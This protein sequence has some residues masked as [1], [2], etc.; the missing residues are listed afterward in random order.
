MKTV[1]IGSGAGGGIA[2]M[3]RA[4]AG[5]EVVM[6]EKGPW[7]R[8]RDY[9]DDEIKFGS[10]AMI[11]QDPRIHPRVAR[12]AGA[13]AYRGRILPASQCVGGGTVHYAA[14]SFRLRPEDFAVLDAFGPVAGANVQNWP[15][16]YDDLE[17]YYTRVE[18]LIG[19]Q[20]LDTGKSVTY[21]KR[22]GGVTRELTLEGNTA[23]AP[24]SLPYPMPP[25][26]GKIDN[27]LFAAAAK[28]LGFHPYPCPLAVNS[29][30]YA[31][32]IRGPRDA[33]TGEF[34][35]LERL[36]QRPTCE[37][38]GMC[39]GYG[40]PIDAKNSTLVTAI[41]A[42]EKRPNFRLIEQAMATEIVWEQVGA[43]L[44]VTG[45]RYRRYGEE[46]KIEPLE[47][48][49]RL[50]VAADAIE[51]PRLFLLSKLDAFD[52]SGDLGCNLMTNHLP[53]AIGFFPELVNNHRGVYTTH[54]IDDLWMIPWDALP[55]KAT[56]GLPSALRDAVRRIGLKGGTVAAAGP[57]AGE[58]FGI[59]GL[60][61]LGQ[62]L[63][64]GEAH[65][66]AMQSAFGHSIYL[67][68]VGDDLPQKTNRVTLAEDVRDVHG[69]PVARIEQLPHPRELAVLA[70]AAP[71]LQSILAKAGAAISMALSA[72][73]PVYPS[74]Y[75]HR[76]GTMRMGTS[77]KTSVVDPDGRFW[78]A[79]NLYVMDGSVMASAGG[80][81]PTE[82]IQAI[83]WMLAERL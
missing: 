46:E 36:R 69:V 24:R 42:I 41:E 4:R 35:V 47:K 3:V 79:D 54:V 62:T 16:T 26:P 61:A 7:W 51:T 38:C 25:G 40:C 19:V 57:S 48:G 52:E 8:G 72:T 31:S 5:D 71:I 60:V 11:N 12:I 29:V 13:D 80:H 76:M 81:N 43:A 1:I 45:V 32:E 30:P 17:P 66:P 56:E 27:L 6:L 68:M 49:D 23:Q 15:F 83:A 74:Q 63:P 21:R 70:A 28:D 50:I 22:P 55:R 20:G 64:W 78:A 77:P 65:V 9:S 18:Y 39:S 14:M 10:R 75:N 37:Q 82:T 59:G 73:L 53:S 34:P 67:G 44:R 2:A 58:P 33:A